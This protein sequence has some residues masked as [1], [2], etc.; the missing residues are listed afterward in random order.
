[1][2]RKRVLLEKKEGKSDKERQRRQAE[3][4]WNAKREGRKD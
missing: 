4:I 3:K 1:M 2:K